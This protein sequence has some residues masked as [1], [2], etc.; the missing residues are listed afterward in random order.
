MDSP[1]LLTF[2]KLFKDVEHL[3]KIAN[4]AYSFRAN[5]LKLDEF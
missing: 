3:F 1:L 4:M 5:M 2:P